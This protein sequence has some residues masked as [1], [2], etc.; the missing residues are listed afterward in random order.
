[1]KRERAKL[2]TIGIVASM[3]NIHP[4][5]LRLYEKE[6]LIKP[7]RSKG[8]T[9]YY[10]EEDIERLEFILTL[11]RDLGVNLAGI[12]II[13]RMKEQMEELEAQIQKLLEFIQKEFSETYQKD[14]SVK[15]ILLA[16]RKDILKVIKKG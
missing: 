4:Q 1:M 3:F 16:E 12:D 9:R 14:E 8:R 7:T 5:T 10:T 6:G 11:S 15:S 13:L 2:Y